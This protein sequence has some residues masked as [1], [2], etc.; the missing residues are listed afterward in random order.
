[1]LVPEGVPDGSVGS[2]NSAKDSGTGDSM[3]SDAYQTATQRQMYLNH[4]YPSHI[5]G[6][7][8]P[9]QQPPA[10]YLP[11]QDDLPSKLFILL[12]RNSINIDK[13]V[14]LECKAS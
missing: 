12:N 3:P 9:L 1:M 8:V 14:G 2:Q 13:N 7:T 6:Y 5:P 11:S 4:Q 10:V